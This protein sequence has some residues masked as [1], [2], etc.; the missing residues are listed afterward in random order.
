[1]NTAEQV[2]TAAALIIG[3]VI[4]VGIGVWLA[5]TFGADA[6]AEHRTRAAHR[7]SVAEATAQRL[8]A[9]QRTRD[10]QRAHGVTL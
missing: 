7:A 8:D 6:L 3:T 5:A 2:V 10:W 4:L 9:A 1:M